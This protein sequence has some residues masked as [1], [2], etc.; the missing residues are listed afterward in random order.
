MGRRLQE[1]LISQEF[2]E[3]AEDIMSKLPGGRSWSGEFLAWHRDGMSF[4]VGVTNTPVQDAQGNVVGVI[5]VSTDITELKRTGASLTEDARLLSTLLSNAPAFLYR[6]RNEPDCPNEFV[7]D[8]A[9]GYAL[10]LTGYTPEELTDGTVMFAGVFARVIVE[11]GRERV[12][13]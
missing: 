2:W 3:S 13:E 7:S 9:L 8:Y 5:G 11:E 12:W 4:A 10:G 1:F 6:C